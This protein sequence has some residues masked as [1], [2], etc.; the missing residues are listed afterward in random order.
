MFAKIFSSIYDS[1]IADDWK[2]RVV[3]QDMLILAD[4][5]GL[6]DITPQAIARRTNIPLRMIREAIPILEGDDP[7]SRSPD[8]NGKRLIRLDPHRTWGWRIVNYIRYRESATKEMLRMAE[9]DRKRAYRAKFPKRPPSSP[10]PLSLALPNSPEYKKQ[11][12][13]SPPTCPDVS[14]TSERDCKENASPS[15]P[16]SKAERI[17]IDNAI[18]RGTSRLKQLEA[19]RPFPKNSP[20]LQELKSLRSNLNELKKQIGVPF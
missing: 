4:K 1:S 13:N 17:S 15:I 20:Q 5:D 9:A 16:I 6:L 12:E 3:F 14:R 8:E 18:S 11:R 7:S 19:Q 10:P 2:V